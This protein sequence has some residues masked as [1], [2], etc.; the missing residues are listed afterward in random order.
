MT[1][2]IFSV[3]ITTRNSTVLGEIPDS[4]LFG[5]SY[6]SD[7]M[8]CAIF[9]RNC[10]AIFDT[11]K[12]TILQEYEV[13]APNDVCVDKEYIY[14]AAGKKRFSMSLP[15]LGCVIRIDQSTG[16]QEVVLDHQTSL[17]GILYQEN[18][19][20]LSRLY[21]VVRYDL[22]TRKIE[23]ITDCNFDEGE[24]YLSDNI[25]I[26]DGIL[27][28]SLY[29]KLEQKGLLRMKS[30]NTIGFVISTLIT[31]IT[32]GLQGEEFDLTNPEQLLSFST[33]DVMENIVYLKYY[34]KE[35]KIEYV[36]IEPQQHDG[37]YTEFGEY[38]GVRI[39]V[40]F[41]NRGIF[42]QNIVGP[43]SNK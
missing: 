22:K 3:D 41:L 39:G 12:G 17:S 31:Q 15:T 25:F 13:F 36:E 42:L 4:T 19:L 7:K 10:V 37:H 32:S 26:E 1:T 21:D 27:Y 16:K 33:G 29:R 23:K 35:K 14:V 9:N 2:V 11:V 18:S 8:Y 20:Y 43:S 24:N 38:K 34:L 6:Q 5:I 30:L 40:N 28:V